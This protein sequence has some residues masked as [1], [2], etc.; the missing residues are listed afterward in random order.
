MPSGHGSLRPFEAR[1]PI[2]TLFVPVAR[3]SRFHFPVSLCSTGITPLLSSYGDSVTFR[4][5]LQAAPYPSSLIHVTPTSRHSLSNDPIHPRRRAHGIAARRVAEVALPLAGRRSVPGFAIVPQARRC[6][7]LNRVQH[8]GV[9][10]LVVRLGLLSTPSLDDA[11]T[12]SY[13]H[14]VF[15]P[16]RTFT[17]LLM[18]ALRRTARPLSRTEPPLHPLSDNLVSDHSK[19]ASD[20]RN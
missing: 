2:A 1:W 17:S 9:Y 3:L 18:C 12:S 8:F 20:Y 6:I 15:C 13:G 7:E 16:E 14:P 19:P 5:R 11:V 10:G 4:A